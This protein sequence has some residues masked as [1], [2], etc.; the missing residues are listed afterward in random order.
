MHHPQLA[1]RP[2]VAGTLVRAHRHVECAS[3]GALHL[4][5]AVRR[6]TLHPGRAVAAVVDRD[7]T[8]RL[9]RDPPPHRNVRTS[10][11]ACDCSGRREAP[12]RRLRTDHLRPA[13]AR[14]E[15]ARALARARS[16]QAGLP[17]ATF[18]HTLPGLKTLCEMTE[19]AGFCPHCPRRRHTTVQLVP[20][21]GSP[22][23]QPTQS[24][25]AI[26]RVFEAGLPLTSASRHRAEGMPPTSRRPRQSSRTHYISLHSWG[27]FLEATPNRHVHAACRRLRS[28]RLS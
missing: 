19:P 15:L 12:T 18:P 11:D 13:V 6:V 25:S 27:V 21:G 24:E 16:C 26:R 22:C 8:G 5:V 4:V 3:A 17:S 1:H 2:R 28:C 10:R 20:S 14:T 7:R 9:R 23:V